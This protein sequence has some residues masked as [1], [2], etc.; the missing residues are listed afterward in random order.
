MERRGLR[1]NMEKTTVMISGEEPM[2]R[3]ESGRY[4]CGCCERGVG[5]NSC[6]VQDVKGGVI[7]DVR[8]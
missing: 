3:M 6:G 5:K 1:V 2:I 4:P 7:R 8:V